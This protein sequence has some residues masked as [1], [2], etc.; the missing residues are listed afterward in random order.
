MYSLRT[1][2][3]K[4]SANDPSGKNHSLQFNVSDIET[5]RCLVWKVINDSLSKL[6][7]EPV[8]TDRLIRWELGSCWIQHL[9]KQETCTND[10]SKSPK[11]VKAE[12][13]VRGLGKEFKMLKKREKRA[14]NVDGNDEIDYRTSNFDVE[15]SIGEVSSSEADLKKFISEEAFLRLKETGTGLHL[16]VSR[17]FPN[18]LMQFV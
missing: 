3:P 9:Q 6:E 7:E 14:G 1:L 16:K 10:T 15:N 8:L 12:T 13:V 2:L 5:S 17:Q 18:L 11:D 4:L